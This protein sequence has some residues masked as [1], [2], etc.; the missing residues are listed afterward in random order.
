MRAPWEAEFRVD[1]SLASRLIA[2][3]FSELA[4]LP[5]R[6]FG[7]GWDNVAYLVGERWV[8]RFPRRAISGELI[9]TE[10]QVL[11]RIATKVPLPVPVP[12][13]A[14]E[15]SAAF[16]WPFCGYPMLPGNALSR[17]VLSEMEAKHAA[18]H[19]GEFLRALHAIDVEN[20]PGLEGDRLGRL[21]HARCMP[22]VMDRLRELAVAG[23]VDNVESFEQILEQNAPL[24]SMPQASAV[25]HGDLY[26]RHIL[27]DDAKHVCGIIDWGDVHRGDPAADI[28]VAFESFSPA[29]RDAFLAGYGEVSERAWMSA[30][31]RALYH[32]AMVAHYGLNVGDDEM[33]RL[34]LAGLS[35]CLV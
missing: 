20:V 17:T 14:G 15:A 13:F 32:S 16:S 24:A 33:L 8:F 3:Q 10:L 34:G 18:Q 28:A 22:K 27:V 26:G 35:S 25:V 5:V 4:P 30:R 1:A 2:A 23:L 11:P 7:E 6:M 9:A 21:D 19:T 29:A 12:Q 31:Y